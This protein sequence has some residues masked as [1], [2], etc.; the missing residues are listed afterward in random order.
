M[1]VS[2]GSHMAVLGAGIDAGITMEEEQEAV[3]VMKVGTSPW[4]GRCGD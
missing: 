4:F 3:E 2:G 1:A